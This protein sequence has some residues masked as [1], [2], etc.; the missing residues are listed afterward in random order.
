MRTVSSGLR[1][2]EPRVARQRHAGDGIDSRGAESVLKPLDPQEHRGEDVHAVAHA[3][4]EVTPPDVS[5]L[6][7]STA[8]NFHHVQHGAM[9]RALCR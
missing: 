9:G 8:E 5:K 7:Q 4:G 2:D 6:A 1:E 3:I